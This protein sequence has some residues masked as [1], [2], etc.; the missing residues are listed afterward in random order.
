ML[1]DRA[2]VII[3]RSWE[4]MSSLVPIRLSN[5]GNKVL[6]FPSP[7]DLK[8]GDS[9][10]KPIALRD[11]FWLDQQGVGSNTAFL[12]L[13]YEEYSRLP[14]AP[15]SGQLLE[16]VRHKAPFTAIYYCGRVSD[17]Q[18]LI[19]ELNSKIEQKDFSSFQ[20]LRYFKR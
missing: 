5:D 10:R 3:Y 9:F 18:Q 11:G 7:E 2:P 12:N 8:K 6:A 13:T 19:I 15:E 4:D 17:F 14:S 16:M 20:D 1:H